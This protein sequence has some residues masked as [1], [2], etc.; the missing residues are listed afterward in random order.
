MPTL[1]LDQK[2][3]DNPPVVPSGTRYVEYYDVKQRGLVLRVMASGQSSYCIRF[4]LKED[5]GKQRTISMGDSAKMKLS[6]ARDKA[7][8]YLSEY[9]AGKKPLDVIKVPK[10]PTVAEVYTAWSEWEKKRGQPK[11]T[12]T[13]DAYKSLKQL[14]T[15]HVRDINKIKIEDYQGSET[16]RGLLPSSINRKL[17]ELKYLLTWAKDH[18]DDL[19]DYS[20]PDVAKL[21]E[22]N[23]EPKKVVLTQQERDSIL[24][25]AK[26]ISQETFRAG[27]NERNMA[28]VYPLIVSLMY[29]GQRPVSILHM[30]WGDV[31]LDNRRIL[32]R[33][34]NNRKAAAT[35]W[36]YLE[37]KVTAALSDWLALNPGT[38]P[39]DKVFQVESFKKQFYALL[40]RIGLGGK[41]YSLYSLRHD[42]AARM[43]EAGADNTEI[44]AAMTHADPR[45]TMRYFDPTEARQRKAIALLDKTEAEDEQLKKAIAKNAGGDSSTE[46][47]HN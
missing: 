17:R 43:N 12:C 24:A 22:I 33:H 6:V 26:R 14:Q 4:H 7:R 27:G 20:F 15:V 36:I 34:V 10:S 37:D 8:D 1:F 44:Q 31:D 9:Q 16:H 45:T 30:T 39:T 2:F 41:G 23:I 28:Y 21:S 5:G 3:C 32:M 19:A 18:V 40:K 25:E 46:K 47:P 29:T 13:H 35:Q 38:Q 11:R 42:F